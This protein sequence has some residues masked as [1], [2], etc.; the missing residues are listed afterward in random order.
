MPLYVDSF[1]QSIDVNSVFNGTYKKWRRMLAM[2]NIACA[3]V[4]FATEVIMFFVFRDKGL[5]VHTVPVYLFRFL[6]LPTFID[7][8][9]LIG[10]KM[11]AK[12]CKGNTRAL[13]YIPIIQMVLMCFMVTS[14]HHVFGV[15]FC[16][17]CF[18]IFLTVMFSDKRMTRAVTVASYI[19]L[20]LA[21]ILGPSINGVKS[22][23]FVPEYLVAVVALIGASI[24]SSVLG[25]F[26]EEKN[27]IIRDIYHRQM[28]TLEQLNLDQKTGLYGSTAFQ[29][30]MLR[31]VG[32]AEGRS[33]PALAVFDI[34]DFKQVND[35]Y[36][37]AKGDE[38]IIALAALMKEKCPDEYLPVRFGGEE[39]A[40]IFIN[41]SVRQYVAFADNIRETFAKKNYN[42]TDRPITVS[43]GIAAWNLGWSCEE[44]FDNADRAMYRSKTAGKNRTTVYNETEPGKAIVCGF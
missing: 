28:V 27:K 19:F 32:S 24:V 4:V 16:T 8:V 6:I 18:P 1:E 7:S 38:V 2:T 42:F 40:I 22:E 20:T 31:V 11:A 9:I 17:Y 33:L 43:V 5:F 13:N 35:T 14:I 25:R 34:D 10:G 21:Q 36:G 15:T 41:G 12:R 39:F 26:Q 44:L 29:N 37:H 3:F 23:Y 30:Q